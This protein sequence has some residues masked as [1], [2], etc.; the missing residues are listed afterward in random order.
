MAG[1]V[2]CAFNQLDYHGK[3]M[4]HTIK[5]AR[6]ILNWLVVVG[7]A[8]AFHVRK[9]HQVPE[10]LFPPINWLE[11]DA[12]EAYQELYAIYGVK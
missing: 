12:D 2:N 3:L 5:T 6:E 9:E 11:K 8:R 7:G 10:G 4:P 1:L